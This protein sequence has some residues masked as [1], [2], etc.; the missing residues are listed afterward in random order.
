MRAEP[1]GLLVDG[2][3][4]ASH[5][6]DASVRII[7]ASFH[8]PGSGRNPADE[9]FARH[10]PGAAFF[11][12]DGIRDEA[13]PLPHMLPPP[14]VFAAR[15]GALGIGND[16][17][18]VAYDA[19]GSLAAPR[20]WW[21]FRAFGHAGVA[22]LDGG[23]G[24]WLAA[25]RPVADGTPKAHAPANFTARPHP[26]LVADCAEILSRLDGGSLQ[27]VD[28]R[29]PGRFAGVEP[30]PR[31][32][33]KRGHIPGSVNIPATSLV[34]PARAGAWRAAQ[35]LAAAFAGAGVDLDRPVIASCGS[36]VTACAIAFA[37][38]ALGHEDVA[39]YDGSW[40]EWGNRED[41][42]VAGRET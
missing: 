1:A 10:I 40:A 3:W 32:A 26:S 22:V 13:N 24:A 18:V 36:G 17:L 2:D 20:A 21:M 25:D 35:D 19:P 16:T 34:D 6:D 41:T 14:E 15:V 30:E 31:P 12:V 37:A 42:P 38:A 28:A 29:G 8:V 9:F 4:R 5:L 39:V 33:R 27:L 11:D 7:D 23:L